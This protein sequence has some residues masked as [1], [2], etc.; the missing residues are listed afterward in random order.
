M[1]GLSWSLQSRSTI[2]S[3]VRTEYEK[4]T[5]VQMTMTRTV[6]NTRILSRRL[7]LALA[8][9]RDI[10]GRKLSDDRDLSLICFMLASYSHSILVAWRCPE[11]F[12]CDLG[13][14]TAHRGGRYP[15]IGSLCW[16]PAC[17][18]ASPATRNS[19]HVAI[20]SR[21]PLPDLLCSLFLRDPVPFLDLP[22][23]LVVVARDHG[24]V[25]VCQFAPFFLYGA[26]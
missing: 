14:S 8:P 4:E 3:W 5:L 22:L 18:L 16:A 20:R 1:S 25:I 17:G 26:F 9:N 15:P 2:S 11:V 6:N 13:E 24:E 19:V 10:K 12:D 21:V 23:Q 7:L